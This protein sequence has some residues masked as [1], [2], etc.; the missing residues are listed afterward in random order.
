MGEK[1]LMYYA[2]NIW[3]CKYSADPDYHVN[4]EVDEF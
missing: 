2:E 1:N 4:N 3:S